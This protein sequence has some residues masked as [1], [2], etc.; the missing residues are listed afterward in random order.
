[1]KLLMRAVFTERQR[2]A[3][4]NVA[5]EKSAFEVDRPRL[6][7]RGDGRQWSHGAGQAPHAP[8]RADQALFLQQVTHGGPFRPGRRRLLPGRDRQQLRRAP[9]W[10]ALSQRDQQRDQLLRRGARMVVRTPRSILEAGPAARLVTR[11]ICTQS[12]D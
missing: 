12:C 5:G 1:M 11:R 2:V 7:G 8:A 3:V 6:I 4:S 9:P 10:V